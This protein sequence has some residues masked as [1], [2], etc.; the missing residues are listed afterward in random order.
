[1]HTIRSFGADLVAISPEL[2]DN[3]LTMQVS[4]PPFDPFR[5]S[6]DGL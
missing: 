1:L 4:L 2:P 6:L 3:T 5:I